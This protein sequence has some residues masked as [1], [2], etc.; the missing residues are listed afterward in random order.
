MGH[1]L[2]Y[3]PPNAL[4][5]VTLRTVGGRFL[6]KPTQLVRV[7]VLAAI[8]RALRHAPVQL[9][10]FVYLSNHAHLLLSVL[11]AA[12]MTAFLQY[13]N[14]ITAR[15]AHD[16]TGWVGQVWTR[17]KHA[18]IL[19]DVAAEQRLEYVMSNGVKEGLVA[20]PSDWPGPSAAAGLLGDGRIEVR[21]PGGRRRKGK[22]P[23]PVT[24]TFELAPLPAWSSLPE[25]TRRARVAALFDTIVERARVARGHKPP[26][27]IRNLLDADPFAVHE[28]TETGPAPLAYASSPDAL[29]RFQADHEAFEVAFRGASH[30]YRRERPSSFPPNS[31]PPSPGFVEG[32]RRAG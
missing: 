13:L 17:P 5:E 26:L 16:A 22:V 1:P 18:V 11:H 21:L 30:G 7:G 10:A 2:C 27:G 25:A 28:L 31:F 23:P 19:D 15:V 6:F 29:A 12:R 32:P 3:V 9:H 4:V 24:S 20:T 8:A 14:A